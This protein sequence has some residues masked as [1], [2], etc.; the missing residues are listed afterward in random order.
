MLQ[1]LARIPG[2]RALWHKFP[3]GSVDV[4][5]RCNVF[6]RPNYAYGV[7]FSAWLAQRLGLKRISAIEFGVAGGN[8]LIA[9]Q[10]IADIIGPRFGIT[11]EVVGFDAGTGLPPPV[12]FRDMP[13]FFGHGYYRM[14]EA[15]LR[16]R[17]NPATK[18]L[19]GNVNETAKEFFGL[20]LGPIGFIAFDLDYYSSTMQ[21]FE[22][23]HG[24]PATRLPR[25]HCYFDD[26]ISSELAGANEYVGEMCAIREFNDSHQ[27]QKITKFPH[28]ASIRPFPSAWNE[29]IYIF[30]DFDHP[31]YTTNIRPQVEH[32]LP[33]D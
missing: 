13:H 20:G 18:L 27:R 24:D 33:L 23:F 10:E 7:Y 30:H 21:A 2:F 5:M 25:V 19:L 1:Q 17:L 29:Q 3:I 15:A 11:V 16:R 12:D 22:I 6:S 9:L 14:D 31:Q 4:R 28:L 26:L 32:E 8:G